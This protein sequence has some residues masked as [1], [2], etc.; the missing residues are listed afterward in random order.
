M[1]RNYEK[2]PRIIAAGLTHLISLSCLYSVYISQEKLNQ[3]ADS[4][5]I[6]N[7]SLAVS[8]G[9]DL[10]ERQR[11]LPSNPDDLVLV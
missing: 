4:E 11:A 5:R 1:I 6:Q 10:G 8:L 7:T 3:A 2:S 9:I